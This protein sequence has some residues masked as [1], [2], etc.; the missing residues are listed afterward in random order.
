MRYTEIYMEQYFKAFHL[1]QEPFP[2]TTT[3]EEL[4]ETAELRRS[5]EEV[6][7]RLL[8]TNEVVL[9][10]APHGSGKSTLARRL[11]TADVKG[12][13]INL[14]AGDTTLTTE[15]IAYEL[16]RQ[17]FTDREID[18][19]LAV[20]MLHKY[21]EYSATKGFKPIIIID[22]ADSLPAQTLHFLL[23]LAELRYREF[24]LHFLLIADASIEEKLSGGQF[25]SLSITLNRDLRI[26]AFTREQT[27]AY[28][29]QRLQRSGAVE[30]PFTSK[31]LDAIHEQ[32][33]GLPGRIH[34][35]ARQF[36]ITKSQKMVTSSRRK[37]IPLTGLA[38]GGVL[39]ILLLTYVL[40]DRNNRSGTTG[41]E[42]SAIDA[43]QKV[44]A[45][46]PAPPVTETGVLNEEGT[47]AIEENT[48]ALEPVSE[49]PQV[50]AQALPAEVPEA[51][52]PTSS[53]TP[54]VTTFHKG[55]DASDLARVAHLY[56]LEAIP[57]Y[58]AGIRGADWLRAQDPDAYCLQLISAQFLQNIEKLLR[59]E[60]G[61]NRDL[62]GYI[63]YT[64]SGKPRYLLFYGIYPDKETATSA[65]AGIP[66]GFARINPWP[67]KIAAIVRDLDQVEQ[68]VREE[69]MPDGGDSPVN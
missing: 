46:Q 37:F 55:P 26:P 50:V 32:S 16:A 53:E 63:K 33:Q 58:L 66:A 21:L 8:N 15:A 65:V 31:E 45:P 19:S 57:G 48:I 13:A 10:T 40:I 68:R 49:E 27:Q 4:F 3:T 47:V 7:Q 38:V 43:T 61:H 67:Q 29:V 22:D 11:K 64:P 2:L 25:T 18:R 60:P 62:S 12:V 17:I 42:T 39:V 28:I 54:P 36:L 35:Q 6:T 41:S 1:H 20:S 44:I 51:Q 69:G 24:S 34:T 59:E 5:L 9:I 30:T 23:Q 52:P 56:H 14:I